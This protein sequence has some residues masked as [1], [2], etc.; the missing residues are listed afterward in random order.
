MKT[1]VPPVLLM[2]LAGTLMWLLT[3]G[4]P[5]FQFELPY[6]VATGFI[7]FSLGVVVIL[8]GILQFSRHKTTVNPLDPSTSSRLTM[9]TQGLT[10]VS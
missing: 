8:Q 7:L 10:A 3:H 4:A 6:S 5:E 9:T 2:I 1:R